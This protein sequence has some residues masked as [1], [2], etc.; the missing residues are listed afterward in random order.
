MPEYNSMQANAGLLPGQ[1]PTMGMT[2]PTTADTST[3]LMAQA[4]MRQMQAQQTMQSAVGVQFRQQFAAIQGQQSMNPYAAQMMAGQMPGAQQ[5]GQGYMPSPLMMT[6]A[7]TGVFRPPAPSGYSPIAPMYRPPLPLTPFQPRMPTPMFQTYYDQQA[8]LEDMRANQFFSY[9]AQ[10]PGV[11]AQGAGMAAGAYAGAR[12]GGRFGMRGRVAGAIGGAALTGFSGLARGFGDFV[13]SFAQPMIESRQMGAEIQNMSQNWVVGGPSLHAMGRGLT[14]DAS[15]QLASQVRDLSGES[16]FQRETGD[17]FNRQDLMRI[18]RQG[19]QAGLFDMAQSVPQIKQQLRATATTIRQ[20]M[21]LTNDPDISNVIREM[22]RLRQF[23]LTQQ[24]MVEAAQGMRAYSRAAGTTIGGLQ[25]MGGLPGA[26]TFQQAGLTAGTGFQYGNYA[27]ASARQMVASGAVSPRQLA[28]LGGV[29]GIAQRDIQAQAAFASMPMFAAMNAQYGAGG[30]GVNQAMTGQAGQG[31]FGMVQGSMQAMGQAVRR[32]GIGALASFPLMQRQ[33]ADEAMANMTPEQ[34]MAQRF[35]MAMQTGRRLGLSGQGAFAAGSRMMFGDEVSEQMMMQASSPEF[36]RAQQQQIRMRR[37]EADMETRRRMMED[38]PM[39]RGIPRAIGSAISG[40]A[41]G[42]AVQRSAGVLGGAWE[43]VSSAGGAIGGFFGGMADYIS[44]IEDY[45]ESGIL[46][47]RTGGTMAGLQAAARRGGGRLGG[48]IS[49]LSGRGAAR[50]TSPAISREALVLAQNRRD[51]GLTGLGIDIADTAIEIATLGGLSGSVGTVAAAAGI[52]L[53]TDPSDQAKMVRDEMQRTADAL[54]IIDRAKK[55]GGEDQRVKSVSASL[56]KAMGSGGKGLGRTV[57]R[58]A[59]DKLDKIVSDRGSSGSSVGA[60]ERRKV[61]KEAI[62]EATGMGPAEADAAVS[63]LFKNGA[64]VQELNT[65]LTHF[66]QKDSRD[67]SAWGGA[68]E[69]KLRK[70][71]WAQITKAT[72]QRKAGFEEEIKG[73]E[74]VLDVDSTFGFYSGQEERI[75]NLAKAEGGARF[76]A[77]AAFAR[78]FLGDEEDRDATAWLKLKKSGALEGIDE[79]TLEKEL[80]GMDK[81]DVK[82]LAEMAGK[83]TP[84][85]LQKYADVLGA[86]GLQDAFASQG[87]LEALGPYSKDLEA[88][89]SSEEGP[90]SAQKIAG[91]FTEEELKKMEASGSQFSKGMAATIRQAK[92]GDKGAIERLTAYAVEKSGIKDG[93]E[94]TTD[95]KAKGKEAKDLAASEEALENVAAM[96]KDFAPATKDFR[97]AAQMFRDAMESDK[98]VALTE[99]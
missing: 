79:A 94:E 29:Q 54:D 47:R 88:M 33:I 43:E 27:A 28:L 9:G 49:A 50:G 74:S 25:Q 89:V 75:Q 42:R 93:K 70:G 26:M 12:L 3:Q 21:E 11:L 83:G 95:V 22:G 72:E 73:L 23:G 58:M 62:Q 56:E 45:E 85:Q 69:G 90:L 14:R 76:A 1:M 2:S 80:A 39:L 96:F 31:A 38:A 41:V 52:G 55:F 30:W 34:A 81:G 68:Q 71:L 91:A 97:E 15:I 60:A 35:E 66:A 16:S 37:R 86:R 48:A 8:Q 13:Q 46:R 57:L 98:I 17:M 10:M 6:P 51:Q 19:G 67:T 5:Y 44:D 24:E 65:Q 64:A 61:V 87:F 53:T 4:S 40:S 77:K 82:R 99:D 92:K 32:G 20:F 63:D 78:A 36:W 84:E 59:A 18:M 7:S